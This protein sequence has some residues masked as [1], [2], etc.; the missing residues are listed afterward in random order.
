M[1]PAALETRPPPRSPGLRWALLLLLRLGQV[2]LRVGLG[3]W[4]EDAGQTGIPCTCPC[5]TR[6]RITRPGAVDRGAES[7]P[8]PGG[9]WGSWPA[10]R[11]RHRAPS[12]AAGCQ[13]EGV[14]LGP[15]RC[16]RGPRRL[17]VVAPAWAAGRSW[18]HLASAGPARAPEA[19]GGGVF[20]EGC[21]CGA[22]PAWP[23]RGRPPTWLGGARGLGRKGSGGGPVLG[24]R[25][26]RRAVG[27]WAKRGTSG[28]RALFVGKVPSLAKVAAQRR[29]L[30]LPALFSSSRPRWCWLF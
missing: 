26:W 9:R 25:A 18:S 4:W 13:G 16:P 20:A 19:A 14:I 30:R 12:P 23:N 17:C 21:G 1:K 10:S 15:Q 24:N 8:P 2:S 28:W 7:L 27:W 5:V 3:V 11:S 6:S 22:G 29:P